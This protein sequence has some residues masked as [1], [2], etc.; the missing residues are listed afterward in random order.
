MIAKNSKNKI[1]WVGMQVY[2]CVSMQLRRDFWDS[3]S[4]FVVYG[5]TTGSFTGFFDLTVLLSFQ[6]ASGAVLVS[7][8]SCRQVLQEDF[9]NSFRERNFSAILNRKSR[10]HVF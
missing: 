1:Y 5:N 4:H 3:R 2:M 8:F 10:D 6:I 7:V 9:F